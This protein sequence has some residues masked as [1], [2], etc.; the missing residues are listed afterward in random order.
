MSGSIDT[1]NRIS[2]ILN[3]VISKAQAAGKLSSDSPEAAKINSAI[4]AIKTHLAQNDLGKAFDVLSGLTP[5]LLSLGVAGMEADIAAVRDAIDGFAADGLQAMIGAITGE[6]I[7]AIPATVAGDTSPE[8]VILRTASANMP[9]LIRGFSESVRDGDF[10]SAR[11]T[12]SDIK[13]ALPQTVLS[14]ERVGLALSILSGILAPMDARR[15]AVKTVIDTIEREAGSMAVSDTPVRGSIM[16]LREAVL[17]NNYSDIKAESGSLIAAVDTAMDRGAPSQTQ[18]T[19]RMA[20][21]INTLRI[22]TGN[23]SVGDIRSA[24]TTGS[25]L[26]ISSAYAAARNDIVDKASDVVDAISQDIRQLP[27]SGARIDQLDRAVSNMNYALANPASVDAAGML[28]SGVD[29]LIKL[30]AGAGHELPSRLDE[31]GSA[32][33]ASARVLRAEMPALAASMAIASS[34]ISAVR[35]ARELD[36]VAM[37]VSGDTQEPNAVESVRGNM[38]N[39]VNNMVSASRNADAP[40]M[41][42]AAEM[43]HNSLNSAPALRRDVAFTSAL[44]DFAGSLNNASSVMTGAPARLAAGA[45]AS[46]YAENIISNAVRLGAAE[47]NIRGFEGALGAIRN[48]MAV[49]FDEPGITPAES[50]DR[51]AR[52]SVNIDSGIS[53]FERAVGNLAQSAPAVFSDSSLAGSIGAFGNSLASA[54]SAARAD[55]PAQ[56][57]RAAERAASRV[58]LQAVSASVAP[59]VADDKA[60]GRTS[61]LETLQKSI[62]PNLSSAIRQGV[63]PA[64][65]SDFAKALDA[66]NSELANT[67]A[68]ANPLT[69]QAVDNF[70]SSLAP[71]ASDVDNPLARPSAVYLV[72]A[73]V[74][75]LTDLAQGAVVGTDINIDG[76]LA[77]VASASGRISEMLAPGA[78]FTASE[79]AG[80]AASLIRAVNELYLAIPQA[81][82]SLAISGAM[83]DITKALVSGIMVANPQVAK[84][85]IQRSLIE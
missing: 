53:D 38:I 4:S 18:T 42:S 10:Q 15:E 69:S 59:T 66:F 39:A 49:N 3:G 58:A 30:S 21:A 82:R 31:L 29:T 20:A 45:A 67:G 52:A 13:N 40:A 37:S 2:G 76:E 24:E 34:A 9:V 11:E 70:A 61:S 1:A 25:P 46:I 35:V 64:S 81:S 26:A 54:A 60:A 56:M 43:L 74:N 85:D 16:T 7:N 75:R 5:V 79:I 62:L 44:A 28:S 73:A 77:K 36:F 22:L 48:A 78:A 83:E 72:N 23:G 68:M 57:V 80:S 50:S 12:L 41:A 27:D 14:N 51:A 84:L 55:A 8:A 65:A 17:R 71:M 63:T 47:Q 19:P 33:T 32:F 6:I